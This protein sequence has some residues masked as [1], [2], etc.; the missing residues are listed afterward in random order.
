MNDYNDYEAT[1][2]HGDLPCADCGEAPEGDECGCRDCPQCHIRPIFDAESESCSMCEDSGRIDARGLRAWERE[3]RATAAQWAEI[4]DVVNACGGTDLTASEEAAM[5][6][7]DAIDCE[8][9]AT[10]RM[11]S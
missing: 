6:D 2:Q 3:Q 7:I 4:D 5:T 1:Q 8:A 11:A 10:T 9:A